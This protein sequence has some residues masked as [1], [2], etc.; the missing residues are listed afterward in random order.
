MD[1]HSL[2]TCCVPRDEY[3]FQKDTVVH[4]AIYII[5]DHDVMI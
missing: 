1:P 4:L 5:V 2:N 3:R